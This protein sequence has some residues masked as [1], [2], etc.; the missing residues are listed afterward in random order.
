MKI[1]NVYFCEFGIICEI[2]MEIVLYQCIER[3]FIFFN[4]YVV[5]F[6]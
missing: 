2:V 1:Y 6:Y 5:L 4:D 3:C